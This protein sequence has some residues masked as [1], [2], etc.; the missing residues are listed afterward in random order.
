MKKLKK[1]TKLGKLKEILKNISVSEK[2]KNFLKGF[3][4]ISKEERN[5]R[6]AISAQAE[7]EKDSSKL[8]WETKRFI[9]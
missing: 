9:G 4:P 5:Y 3:R 6:C 8:P 1:V 2:R 7:L